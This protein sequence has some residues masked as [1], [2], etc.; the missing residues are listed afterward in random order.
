MED[1]IELLE[2]RERRRSGVMRMKQ[3][4]LKRGWF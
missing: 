1:R 4:V 3:E 2:R